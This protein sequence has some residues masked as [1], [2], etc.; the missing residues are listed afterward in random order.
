VTDTWSESRIA[1]GRRGWRLTLV[2]TLISSLG[3]GLT[4]PF[5]FVYLNGVRGIPL[6]LAGAIAAVGAVFAFALAPVSGVIG[7][8]VG[9]GRLLVAGLVLNGVGTGLLAVQAG[10]AEAFVAVALTAAGNSLVFPALNGM[11]AAQLPAAQRPRAYGLRFG[12]LNAGIGIGGLVSGSVVSLDRPVS[13]QIVY[14]V[15][16]ASTIA[17]AALVAV[18]MRRTP[19]FGRVARDAGDVDGA[20]PPGRRG[21]RSVLANRPFVGF[22]ACSFL[23]SLFGYA[24]LDGPWAAY[25]TLVVG[26]DP[27]VV[28]IAFA[29]NTAVIVVCQLG[30]SRLTTRWRRSRLLLGAGALWALAWA[31]S[32]ATLL[33]AV[34][35]LVSAVALVVSL[36][37]FGLGETLFSPVAGGLPNEL[38]TDDLRARYNA[39]GSTTF[40]VAG[41]VGPPMAGLLLGS[42]APWLW[43]PVVTI[44]MLA[45]ALGAI[46]LGRM[47]PASVERPG[48]A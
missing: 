9:L 41:F 48:S 1:A 40:S 47:L 45:A 28:G 26:V 31:V 42:S 44:G 24:Q 27:Q 14:L 37:V 35:G 38:A 39:L 29:A 20:V 4:L 34:H 5:L 22:L 12:V 32:G 19:G 3:T 18:G 2:G 33:P 6:P 10:V 13:F 15:D 25:A 8:R 36:A 46:V 11:V 17:F 23:F 16:A 21:Y 7:D 43:A 30:V